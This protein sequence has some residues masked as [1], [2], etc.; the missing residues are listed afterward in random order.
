MIKQRA[1]FKDTLNL[2]LNA[3]QTK[4][5][6]L[7]LDPNVDRLGR[8][9]ILS[10]GLVIPGKFQP[11]KIFNDHSLQELSNSIEKNG[12]LQPLIV[13]P[14]EKDK[15]EIIAGERR[16]RAAKMIGLK[17]IP[18]IIRAVDDESAIAFAILENLQREDLNPIEES[19]AFKQLMDEFLLTHEDISLKVGK[20]RV[21]ITNSLR[22]LKLP[23]NIQDS[24]SKGTIQ[25]GH[26]KAIASLQEEKLDEA[27][28]QIISR[29]LSVRET[30]SLVKRL[31]YNLESK[32][33]IQH[34]NNQD[35]KQCE[36]EFI[37]KFKLPCKLKLKHSGRVSLEITSNDLE[38]LKDKLL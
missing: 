27:Y 18:V 19:Y 32:K 36:I 21:Y 20:S 2:L 34:I 8:Y 26:A 38:E 3:S 29:E 6:E 35:L 24:L 12:V 22:L 1:S 4:V 13:R 30:E 7:S 14:L 15:Y 9:C 33:I 37:K 31:N 5:A 28:T 17:E 11:R 25:V 10:I 16:W 23:G